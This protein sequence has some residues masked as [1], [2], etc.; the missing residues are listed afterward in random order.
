MAKHRRSR[1]RAF[2]LR[3]VRITN[4]V[5]IGAL[6]ADDVIEGPI[7][8]TSTN[9]YRVI[10]VNLSYG[11]S[12][13]GATSDDGQEFGLAHGDYTAVE[14]EECLEAAGAINV[15][16]KVAQER[17]NR[18]VRSIGQMT[19]APGTGAGL[20]YNDGKPVKTKLNWF[21]GIGQ[22]VVLWIRNT[23]GTIYT[24]GASLDCIGEMWVK[25]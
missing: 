24:T 19:G 2:N 25:D 10:S 18:L 20:S 8:N 12:D 22:T 15:G 7:S 16:D 11:L 23:S 13:L 17:A 14:I 3:K 1:R 6:A 5:A 4:N 21:I 9:T